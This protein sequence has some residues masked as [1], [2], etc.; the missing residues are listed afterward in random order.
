MK[1]TIAR[2]FIIGKSERGEQL[3]PFHNIIMEAQV[4]PDA[5]ASHRRSLFL[6]FASGLRHSLPHALI[7]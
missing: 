2:K 3:N 5:F 4:I 1:S 6:A 7:W